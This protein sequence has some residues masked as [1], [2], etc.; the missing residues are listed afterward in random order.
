MEKVSVWTRALYRQAFYDQIMIDGFH[1]MGLPLYEPEGAFYVFPCI[2]E[3]GLS[4]MEFVEKLLEEQEVLVIPGI[5]SVPVVKAIS[6]APILTVKKSC[7]RRW[8][9][10]P[11]S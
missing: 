3:T 7:I 5:S 4:S 8:S 6:V 2:K 9:A 10:S 1:K 11:S